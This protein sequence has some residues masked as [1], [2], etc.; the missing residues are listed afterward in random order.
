MQQTTYI[1][2]DV[3]RVNSLPSIVPAKQGDTGRVIQA[4]VT[5][6]GTAFDMTGATAIARIHKPDGTNCLYDEG[7]T[8]EGNVVTVPLVDQALTAHGRAKG[9]INLYTSDADRITTFDFWIDIEKST[10]AD[11]E[12]VSSDYYNALTQTAA[13]ILATNTIYVSRFF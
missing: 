12:I 9:E 4:T 13:Q 3:G 5:D 6:K 11:G 7:I 10:V 2:I 8:V 1:T